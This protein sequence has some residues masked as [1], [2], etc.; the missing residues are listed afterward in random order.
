MTMVPLA[1]RVLDAYGGEE[2]WRAAS[3]VEATLSTGGVALPMKGRRGFR[4][5]RARVRVH[6]PHAELDDFDHR[7]ETG[8]ID[9]QSV[10]IE[11]AAGSVVASRADPRSQFP[12][13]RRTFWWDRL[14]LVYFAAY[15][16]W[17]YV[18]FPALLLRD[19]IEWSGASDSALDAR[20]PP[21]LPTH[22]PVQRFHFD[23]AT[24]LL[25]QHD[26]TAE[27]FGGWA[28]AAHVVLEHRTWQGVQ[29][30]AKRRVTPR[31]PGGG[32]WPAPVLVSI[33]LHDW[34]LR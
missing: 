4:R 3:V 6:E 24:A 21:H 25:T 2:R 9:G 20:F 8:V 31:R 10:R 18:A 11:D 26:Y 22:C 16:L 28:R 12:S 19:D 32:P 17:N 13:G 15:A 14:D 33:E 29:V 5:M 1:R 34:A 30:P 27:V 7:G 23:P